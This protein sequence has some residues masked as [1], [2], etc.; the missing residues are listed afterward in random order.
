MG[1]EALLAKVIKS[2]ETWGAA[3]FITVFG[4]LFILLLLL[5]LKGSGFPKW[6]WPAAKKYQETSD[7]AVHIKIQVNKLKTILAN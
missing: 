3:I 6:I 7:Q 5:F 1:L 4:G 2:W